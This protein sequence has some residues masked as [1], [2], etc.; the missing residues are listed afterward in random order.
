MPDRVALNNV[1]G[2]VIGFSFLGGGC[3]VS[4]RVIECF[5]MPGASLDGDSENCLRSREY[6]IGIQPI[7]LDHVSRIESFCMSGHSHSHDD[8]LVRKWR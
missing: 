1:N 3:R 8:R 4:E 6:R 2:D 5:V 7:S